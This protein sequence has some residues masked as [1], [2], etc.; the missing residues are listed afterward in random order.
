MKRRAKGELKGILKIARMLT[1]FLENNLF[2]DIS[3][4]PDDTAIQEIQQN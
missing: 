4:I 1:L 3:K 2:K